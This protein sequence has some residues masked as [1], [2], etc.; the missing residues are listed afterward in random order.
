MNLNELPR[1]LVYPDDS[2][3][4]D[5][6]LNMD[7]VNYSLGYYEIPTI[8]NPMY[9]P[10]TSHEVDSSEFFMDAE[11]FE[12]YRDVHGSEEFME[13]YEK[14]ITKFKSMMYRHTY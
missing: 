3:G 13:D 10:L 11:E 4:L 8:I 5:E 14:D 1:V 9:D 6:L 2:F 12:A 7:I